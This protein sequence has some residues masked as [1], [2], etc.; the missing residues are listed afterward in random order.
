MIWV[1]A[2]EGTPDSFQLFERGQVRTESSVHAKD[3]SPDE[4]RERHVFED[5]LELSPYPLA[6]ESPSAFLHKAVEGV[7][8][9]AFVIASEKKDL[10]GIDNFVCEKE[11]DAFQTLLASVHVVSEK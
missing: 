4:S 11:H 1:F 10:V 2:R 7:D 9:L 5:A 3:L 6:F 8:T